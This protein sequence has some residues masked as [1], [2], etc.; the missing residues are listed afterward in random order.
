VA[1]A[2]LVKSGS[3]GSSACTFATGAPGSAAAISGGVVGVAVAQ[4]LIQIASAATAVAGAFPKLRFLVRRR[5]A[6]VRGL[7]PEG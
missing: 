3:T 2:V 5:A 7:T 6:V 1:S 4:A